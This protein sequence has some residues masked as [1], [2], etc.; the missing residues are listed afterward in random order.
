MYQQRHTCL[1]VCRCHLLASILTVQAG[2]LLQSLDYYVR[3][4]LSAHR[5]CGVE[6]QPRGNRVRLDGMPS[7]RER[8]I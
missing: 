6:P 1:R 2:S 7:S 4:S 5:G 8:E 3:R